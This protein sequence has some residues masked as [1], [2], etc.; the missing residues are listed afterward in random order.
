MEKTVVFPIILN[1]ILLKLVT[2]GLPARQEKNGAY[3]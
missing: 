1:A 3:K 2:K